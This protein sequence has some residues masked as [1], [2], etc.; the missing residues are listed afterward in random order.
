MGYRI[1]SLNC[2]NFCRNGK[3]DIGIFAK[4]IRGEK[5]DL[6]VF[7]E[8]QS[9]VALE[10][11][12]YNLNCGGGTMW[13]GFHEQD[14][15]NRTKNDHFEYGFIWNTKKLC[16]PEREELYGTKI[17]YPRIYKQ[18]KID[19][20]NGQTDLRYEPLFGRF[21]TVSGPKFEIRIINTHI[22]F[23]KGKSEVD[24]NIKEIQMRRN[25]LDI[26]AKAIYA[27]EADRTYKDSCASTAFTIL[28]GDYN[29]NKR[30]SG[31]KNAFLDKYEMIHISDGNKSKTILTEQAELTTL[32]RKPTDDNLY[33]NNYDHIT[34]DQI[35]FS[36]VNFKM[37]RIN[38]I[39]KY[40]N[41]DIEMYR[42]KVSDHL[43]IMI[44]IEFNK[45]RPIL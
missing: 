16:L 12:L 36:D 29:L 45:R 19:R 9:K 34:F 11:I 37:S 38:A 31:A 24:D 5:L 21:Q 20:R 41:N 42:E 33:S 1:G 17:T 27:K 6:M 32:K 30:N 25:E 28:L 2:C 22:M 23:S 10:S 7:Q 14:S 39:E 8:L 3:K 44:E 13:A 26:L 40:C 15:Y 43:P 35:H 4:I 18:Y